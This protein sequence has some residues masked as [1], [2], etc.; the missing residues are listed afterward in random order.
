MML[1]IIR[2][3]ITVAAVWNG[4]FLA[5]E[6]LWVWPRTVG[7]DSWL[8]S[9]LLLLACF[10]PIVGAVWAILRPRR[11]ALVM[12]AAVGIYGVFCGVRVL[13]QLARRQSLGWD[14]GPF[15]MFVIP[16]TVFAVTLHLSSRSKQDPLRDSPI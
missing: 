8:D 12:I 2:W 7:I 9:T 15:Y 1:R 10:L 6:G 14:W 11:G 4:L 16:T 3:L 13:E 5:Y